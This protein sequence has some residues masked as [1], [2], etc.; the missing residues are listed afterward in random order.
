MSLCHNIN[1]VHVLYSCT[2][3]IQVEIEMTCM[4]AMLRGS[5]L[6]VSEILLLFVFVKFSFGIMVYMYIVNSSEKI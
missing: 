2:Q 4:Q 5:A 1:V 3:F 6:F